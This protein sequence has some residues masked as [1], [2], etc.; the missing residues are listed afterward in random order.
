MIGLLDI[1]YSKYL[2]DIEKHNM[3][4]LLYALLYILMNLW[5]IDHL[6][7]VS[8]L[9]RFKYKSTFIA[10]FII[11]VHVLRGDWLKNKTMSQRYY[12]KVNQHAVS[13]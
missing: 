3:I 2:A 6:V 1:K 9:D 4:Y 5:F 12:S 7:Y 13:A 10:T 8:R 11:L